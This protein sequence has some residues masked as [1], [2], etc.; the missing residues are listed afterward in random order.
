MIRGTLL[1]VIDYKRDIPLKETKRSTNS[2]T[3]QHEYN[4]MPKRS[5]ES[6]TKGKKSTICLIPPSFRYSHF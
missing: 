5:L 4:L 1:L 2:E 6:R 3:R